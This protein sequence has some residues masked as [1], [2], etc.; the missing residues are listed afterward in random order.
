MQKASIDAVSVTSRGCAKAVPPA[1]FTIFA[2]SSRSST[3]RAPSPTVQPRPPSATA[4]ARPIPAEA[5]VT[6]ATRASGAKEFTAVDV[7]RLS[8][9]DARPRRHEEHDA[10]R[11]LVLGR[12]QAKRDPRFDLGAHVGAR[13]PA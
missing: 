12:D 8:G 2:V 13:D 9:D 6:T 1:S 7:E 3:R 5:P 4:I 10:V 11:D